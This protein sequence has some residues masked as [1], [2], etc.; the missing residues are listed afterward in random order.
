MKVLGFNYDKISIEKLSNNFE[1]L[2]INSGIDISEIKSVKSG[3]LRSTGEIVVIK[4]KYLINFVPNIAQIDF[5]GNLLL[6]LEP[7]ISRELFKQWKDKKIHEEFKLALF[8]LIIKKCNIKALQLEDELNLPYHIPFPS[9][10][11]EDKE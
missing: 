1:G 5:L 2:T 8:N 4:F 3:F 6:E 10:K 11:K 7:R 9:L